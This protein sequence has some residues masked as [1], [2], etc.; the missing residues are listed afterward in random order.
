MAVERVVGFVDG[1]PVYYT[2]QDSDRYEATAA[3][4]PKAQHDVTIEAEDDHGNITILHSLYYMLGSWIEPIWQRTQA[5]VDYARYLNNKITRSGW[6]SLTA[7]EQAAWAAGQIGCLNYWDLNRI[8]INTEYLSNYLNNYM[9]CQE[10]TC[11]TD[12]DMTDFP[13]S[14]EMERIRSNIQILIDAFYPQVVALPVSLEQPNYQTVNA[15][16]NVLKLIKEMIHRMEDS[17]RKVGTFV[18][19]QAVTL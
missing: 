1:E 11:K 13:A 9:Y 17:F 14:A 10:I 8:E 6:A 15:V 2:E 3:V 12:W 4:E 16:E 7:E 19:G 18:S 5:D